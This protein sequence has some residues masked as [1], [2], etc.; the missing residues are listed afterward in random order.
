MEPV[1]P[2]VRG[3]DQE[4]AGSEHARLPQWRW[5][6]DEVFVKIVAGEICKQRRSAAL[7]EWRALMD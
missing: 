6:L 1:W 3:G 7:G 2:D 5:H 4:K